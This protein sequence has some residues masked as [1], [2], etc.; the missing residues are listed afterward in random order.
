M[1]SR[2]SQRFQRLADSSESSSDD[3]EAPPPP[4]RSRSKRSSRRSSRSRTRDLEYD[5]RALGS[6]IPRRSRKSARDDFDPDQ[7]I[8]PPRKGPP[9]GL[10]V[11]ILLMLVALGIAA[12]LAVGI[13]QGLKWASEQKADSATE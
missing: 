3:Y 4:R 2:H 7:P 8:K 9:G 6:I 1:P 13:Y 10:P 5:E 12:A 11:F